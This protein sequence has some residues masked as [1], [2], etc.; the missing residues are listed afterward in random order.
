MATWPAK[1]QMFVI[2]LFKRSLWRYEIVL[3]ISEKVREQVKPQGDG[4]HYWKVPFFF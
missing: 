1:H 2:W 4:E 3:K